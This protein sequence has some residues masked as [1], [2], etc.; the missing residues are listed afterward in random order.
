MTVSAINSV[1]SRGSDLEATGQTNLSPTLAIAPIATIRN[2]VIAPTLSYLGVACTAVED[3]ILGTLLVMSSVPQRRRAPDGIG[4]YG[5]TSRLHTQ[6]WD[7][8]LALYPDQASRVRGLASQ[9]CF[10]KDPHAELGFNLAYATAIAWT[11][12]A[13]RNVM[14]PDDA[15]LTDLAR[16]WQSDYPHTGGR[17]NDFINT[18]HHTFGFH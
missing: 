3:L 5:I 18:W 10:L 14:L 6:L 12:Y 7:N 4:P 17:A 13:S 16:V 15:E 1:V 11:V 8:Y 2:T 9:H